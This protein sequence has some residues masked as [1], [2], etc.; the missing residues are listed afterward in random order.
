MA[1]IGRERTGSVKYSEKKKAWI[2]RVTYTDQFGKRHDLRRMAENRTEGKNL[3]KQLL[4]QLED[5]GEKS[6]DGDRLTFRKLAEIYSKHKIQPATYQGEA[7][8]SGLRSYRSLPQHIRALNEYFGAR[9]IKS[10]TVADIEAFKAQR[11]NTPTQRTGKPRT[12]AH[13]NRTLSLMRSILNYAKR[14]GWIVINPFEKGKGMIES[15]HEV[16]R[17]RILSKDEEESLLAACETPA[18][19]HLRPL[20]ICA[21]DTAMRFGEIVQLRWSDVDLGGEMIRVRATTTKTM[22]ARTIG[23]TARL[24]AEMER[25]FELSPPDEDGLV[26]GIKSN[27][28]RS[29]AAACKDAGIEG[30][31]FHDAR[32]TAITR[33]IQSGLPPM[34]VMRI[35]GHTQYQ[36]FAR[37]VNV[38]EESARRAASAL[39]DWHSTELDRTDIVN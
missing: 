9:L 12:I 2:V 35:S 1:R 33:M 17:D 6:I 37:Y 20:L 38:N 28:K 34:V 15:S 19:A 13:V 10:I 30:F 5:R 22:T 24:K 21:L 31:R 29:F 16:R 4:R 14:E 23:L 27:V 8:I 32:H 7:K 3:L 25:L 18:R 36:T 26:F 11:L 39:D